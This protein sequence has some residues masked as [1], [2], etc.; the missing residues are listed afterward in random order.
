MEIRRID[1]QT[2]WF[3]FGKPF[4]T[5]SL[6]FD[7]ESAKPLAAMPT[8]PWKLKQADHCIQLHYRMNETTRVL[9]LGENLR[10]MNKRGGLYESFCTDDPIH[11]PGKK[12]LY[13]AHNFLSGGCSGTIRTF[14]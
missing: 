4:P 10:G 8:T 1:Y 3:A 6:L 12:S 11:T 14:H 2:M 9:G 5:E 13:G 7:R